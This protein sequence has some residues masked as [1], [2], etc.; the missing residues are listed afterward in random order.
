MKSQ[1][2]AFTHLLSASKGER[3]SKYTFEPAVNATFV[4]QKSAASQLSN[5]PCTPI[6]RR[7]STKEKKELFISRKMFFLSL[8]EM[9][10]PT[11]SFP[12]DLSFRWRE[13]YLDGG[14]ELKINSI[15]IAA[16]THIHT[17]TPLWLFAHFP[18][19][20]KFSP[21]IIDAI[22]TRIQFST[23]NL[24]VDIDTYVFHRHLT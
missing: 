4:L 19:L 1:V 2:N 24:F 17:Y 21:E 8:A 11:Q 7:F 3:C 23:I 14:G 6:N 15:K 13:A 10:S 20:L 18:I 22:K 9:Q 16:S 12:R 5:I